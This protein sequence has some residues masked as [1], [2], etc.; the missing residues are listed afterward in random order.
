V[1]PGVHELATDETVVCRCEEISAA[2]IDEAI[3]EGAGDPNVV[4]AVTRA[5]MGRCQGRNCGSH[6]AAA[7][8]R[9]TDQAIDTVQ[10]PSVRPPV[11]PVTIAAIASE[12]T[13][14]K[15]TADLD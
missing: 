15:A 4:R 6:I 12:R 7:V 8:A 9:Q 5:G 1:G 11:K 10:L 2:T 14:H 13:Q 3:S